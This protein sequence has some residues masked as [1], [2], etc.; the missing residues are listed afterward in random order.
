MTDLLCRPNGLSQEKL[1]LR[2]GSIEQEGN[3]YYMETID[4]RHF[5]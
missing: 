5:R 2:I 1:K 4:T 3:S